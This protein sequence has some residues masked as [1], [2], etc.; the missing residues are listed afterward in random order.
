MSLRE[1]IKE[2][3]LIISEE[4]EKVLNQLNENISVKVKFADNYSSIISSYGVFENIWYSV[5]LNNEILDE[6]NETAQTSKDLDYYIDYR[7]DEMLEEDFFI[8]DLRFLYLDNLEDYN[9]YM[10]SCIYED[11]NI[12]DFYIKNV[13][14]LNKELII[15]VET[16]K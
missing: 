3:Y 16:N 2:D 12:K 5:I 13:Y 1:M 10:N 6:V 4:L 11:K 14:I 15:E 8:E 7:K 9:K